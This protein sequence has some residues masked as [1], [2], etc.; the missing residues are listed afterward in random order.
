MSVTV[1]WLLRV[2]SISVFRWIHLSNPGILT[3]PRLYLGSE[4]LNITFIQCNYSPCF[5]ERG[6]VTEVCPVLDHSFVLL[7][8]HLNS[9][10][11]HVYT[12]GYGGSLPPTTPETKEKRKADGHLVQIHLDRQPSR[13]PTKLHKN[14]KCLAY[15]IGLIYYMDVWIIVS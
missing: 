7:R 6:K 10:R 8:I 9:I 15:R 3:F 2:I 12:V 1:L 13:Q 4:T 5:L 14:M 11:M